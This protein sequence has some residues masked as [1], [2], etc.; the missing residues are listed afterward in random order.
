MG[1]TYLFDADHVLEIDLGAQ[2]ILLHLLRVRP[3]DNRHLQGLCGQHR[4]RQHVGEI[5]A[6]FAHN[7]PI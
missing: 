1:D 7:A 5:P 4:A 3:G 6:A 2:E